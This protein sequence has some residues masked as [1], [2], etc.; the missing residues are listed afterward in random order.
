MISTA[1]A[2]ALLG[3]CIVFECR[4]FTEAKEVDPK[5]INCEQLV[6]SL[7]NGNQRP[8]LVPGSDPQFS[9]N[10]DFEEQRRIAKAIKALQI[11]AE[12]A[13]QFLVANL[14]NEAYSITIGFNDSVVNYSVGQVCAQLIRNTLASAYLGY[15][16]LLQGTAVSVNALENPVF[17]DAH[18]LLQWAIDRK[19]MSLLELQLEVLNELATR[20][21][22]FDLPD[23]KKAELRES[24]AVDKKFL[25]ARGYPEIALGF[26]PRQKVWWYLSND[27]SV[28]KPG[29]LPTRPGGPP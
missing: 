28:Q 19:N 16:D 1:F 15:D 10:Y 2:K 14:Q 3:C 27:R 13:W 18:G 7:K 17:T 9:A 11:Y 5:V 23:E 4:Q 12:E 6:E 24:T 8:R 29:A 22:E 26:M 21:T 25:T 20:V